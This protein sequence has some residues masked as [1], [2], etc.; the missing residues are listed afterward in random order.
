MQTPPVDGFYRLGP[1]ESLAE[2]VHYDIKRAYVDSRDNLNQR[3]NVQFVT[4][5][6]ANDRN[7]EDRTVLVLGNLR[8]R[9]RGGG[10]DVPKESI[11]EFSVDSIEA[12][13]A[14]AAFLKVQPF[15][16]KHPG[17][18]P[19]TGFHPAKEL[20]TPGEKV[21]L[22]MTITNVGKE[23]VRFMVGGRNRGQ[24]DNQFSFSLIR[25]NKGVL[26]TG[27]PVNFGGI[28]T[29]HRLKPGEAFE[30]EIDLDLWFDT[31]S[32]GVYGG[33][34]TY[35]LEFEPEDDSF[36]TIWQDVVAGEFYFQ[37]GGK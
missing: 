12:A 34:G 8:F 20:F 25:D 1:Q 6:T 26:D 24:R 13:K 16:R 2:R 33:T 5:F 30:K 3:F 28:S 22:R 9:V 21:T 29:P 15:F 4:P 7:Q 32:P 23:N 35:A 18:R 19:S 31:S 14:V 11:Y 17:Y 36:H 27:D 10:A 37:R